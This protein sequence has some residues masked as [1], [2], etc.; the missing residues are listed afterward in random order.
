MFDL[1]EEIA[2]GAMDMKGDELRSSKSLAILKG[3]TFFCTPYI[4]CVAGKMC[5]VKFFAFCVRLAWASVSC[6]RVNSK[7]RHFLFCLQAFA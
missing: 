1:A 3:Q 7:H 2:G 4:C 6:A 5:W